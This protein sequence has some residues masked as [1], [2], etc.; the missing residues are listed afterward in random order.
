MEQNGGNMQGQANTF[1]SL[2]AFLKQQY[3]KKKKEKK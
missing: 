3:P 1:A 2:K